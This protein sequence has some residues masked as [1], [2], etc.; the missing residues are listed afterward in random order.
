[1]QNQQC[2]REWDSN[3][4]CKKHSVAA[5]FWRVPGGISLS[6][7]LKSFFNSWHFLFVVG[8][9][10]EVVHSVTSGKL[11]LPASIKERL[12]RIISRM[13]TIS[14]AVISNL[15][16]TG[17]YD[18]FK[19]VVAR[20]YQIDYNPSRSVDDVNTNISPLQ[21]VEDIH[22]YD[23]GFGDKC[24]EELIGTTTSSPGR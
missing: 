22:N 4:V 12:I 21:I 17:Y 11:N 13:E 14:H 10:I 24:F 2:Q 20:P 8:Q 18:K 23:E 1:M 3:A 7:R 6:V 19:Y 5:D 9:L 16:D 15:K